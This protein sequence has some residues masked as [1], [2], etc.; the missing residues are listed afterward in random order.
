MDAVSYVV[1]AAFS[2]IF[3]FLSDIKSTIILLKGTILFNF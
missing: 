2:S 3:I 1:G